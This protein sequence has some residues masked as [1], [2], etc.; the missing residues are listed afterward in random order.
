MVKVQMEADIALC[1][2]KVY[3]YDSKGEVYDTWEQEPDD[4]RNI[5]W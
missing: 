2:A 3:P 4:N 5:D 1:S